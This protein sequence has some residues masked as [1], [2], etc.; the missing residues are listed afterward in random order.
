MQISILAY[1]GKEFK[2]GRKYANSKKQVTSNK[3]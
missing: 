2:G 1:F 3:Q